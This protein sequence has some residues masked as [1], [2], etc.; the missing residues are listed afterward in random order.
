MW[1]M[2]TLRDYTDLNNDI[3]TL[4]EEEYWGRIGEE[5]I[6]EIETTRDPEYSEELRQL[7]RQCLRISSQNRPTAHELYLATSRGLER[8][9]RRARDEGTDP[10]NGERCTTWGT[11]SM[12]CRLVRK[13]SRQTKI[14]LTVTPISLKTLNGQ[15]FAIQ[16]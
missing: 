6:D 4:T 8:R 10:T 9:A 2:L 7:I 11:R 12:T 5:A 14:Y 15:N 16:I 13:V 3:R 1:E